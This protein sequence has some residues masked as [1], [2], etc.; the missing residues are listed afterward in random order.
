MI[1]QAQAITVDTTA[2]TAA[3]VPVSPDPR[4]ISVDSIGI[5]FSEAVSGLDLSRLKLTRNNSGDLLTGA[6]TVSSGDNILW[7]L[8]NLAGLTSIVGSYELDLLSTGST[9]TDMA[10]NPYADNASETFTVLAGIVG[11]Q[12]FYNESGTSGTTVRYDGNDAAI[13]SLDDNAIAIDKVAYLPGAGAATFANTSSYFKGINGVMID[14][15]GSHPS[16]TAADFVFRVGNNN[17]PS[18]WAT[19]PAPVSVS[20]RAG[21]GIS[22][23]D[24]VEIIWGNHDIANTWLQVI[25]LANANTGLS[26]KPGYPA[27]Q[28]DVFFFGNAIGN[29][30]LGDTVVN[31]LVNSIDENGVRSN[32]QFPFNNIP[33]TNLYDFNR[34]GGVNSVDESIARLNNTNPTTALKYLNLGNPPL[35]PQSDGGSDVTLA[36]TVA[37]PAVISSQTVTNVASPV[38]P[39]NGDADH[40]RSFAAGVPIASAIDRQIAKHADFSGHWLT[41]VDEQLLDLLAIGQSHS[42]SRRRN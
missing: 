39:A 3:I 29:T 32:N 30:G 24:R 41:F 25:T 21:A 6:Q 12:L 10:G 31:A 19:A 40:T 28:A 16:I 8:A 23:A 20:V 26:E 33:I 34:N 4:T 37:E 15:A 1:R 18:S 11:R 27:G 5:N 42:T 13:N 22:G 2:P 14:I 35:A 36:L 9:I 17:T 7:T 38:L